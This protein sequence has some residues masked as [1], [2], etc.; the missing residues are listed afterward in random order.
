MESL[1]GELTRGFE[2]KGLHAILLIESFL[3]GLS[4]GKAQEIPAEALDM[5][6]KDIDMDLLKVQLLMMSDPGACLFV[7]QLAT[8]EENFTRK[9][10]RG[11][12]NFPKTFKNA[13]KLLWEGIFL[14]KISKPVSRFSV[15]VGRFSD[16]LGRKI[17][18]RPT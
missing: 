1:T 10:T 11:F 4:N 15:T 2:Q 18:P 14:I 13:I 16:P 8:R 9:K 17:L 6:S 5:Y 12:L 3:I 7:W